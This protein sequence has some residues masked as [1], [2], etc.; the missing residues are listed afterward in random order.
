MEFALGGI[1]LA[2]AALGVML[3]YIWRA[4]GR[5]I[6]IL[7]EGQKEIIKGI[8]GIAEGQREMSKLLIGIAEGQREMSKLLIEVYKKVS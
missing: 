4:N 2:L 3:T 8:E 1:G 5:A 7:Q 6:R